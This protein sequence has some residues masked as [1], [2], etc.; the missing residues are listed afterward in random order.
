[1]LSRTQMMKM[2]MILMQKTIQTQAHAKAAIDL[3]PLG[4]VKS[5]R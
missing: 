2:T 5:H 4:L 1:M 3:H